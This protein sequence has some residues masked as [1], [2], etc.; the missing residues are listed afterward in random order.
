VLPEG[1]EAR[2]RA[3]LGS[4]YEDFLAS[5]DRPLCTGLRRNPLKTGF[6]GDLSRF[7]L[8]PVPWCPTGFY[9]DAVSRPGLSPYHAAGL[10][11]LQE[12]SAMAPAELLDPQPGERVLDLCAAPGGKST[13][14]AGKLR[15]KGLLVCNEI[16]AKRAKILSGNIERLG[17]S[18]A[19]VLNEHPKRLEERFAGYFDKILVDAPCSGE[20]MFRKNEEA[21]EQWSTQNVELCADRQDEILDC[22]A[23]ML[24]G[25]GR[26]VYSTCTFAPAEDEGSIGRFLKRHPEFYVEEVPLAE[27][28]SH[29]LGE[30]SA[31]IRLWP[32]KLRGEGHYVAVL[33]K[34]G[35][36]AD[37]GSGLLKNGYE[38]GITAGD[39]KSAAAGI[40]E[41]LAFAGETFAGDALEKY[42]G[43]ECRYLKFGEQL[44]RIPEGMPSVKGLKVLRPGLHLGTAKKGR[45]EPSHALALTLHAADVLHTMDLPSDGREIR[46]YLN[47]ETFPAQGEKGWYLITVDGYSTGWGKLAGGIMKNHYPKGLRKRLP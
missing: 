17:I 40:P 45:F 12:P 35:T 41:Y 5:F 31:T 19:L 6:T 23:S 20:G 16:N 47:G 44:Y 34:E 25:G 4:E 22:A 8:S 24:A 33:R 21:C 29:G 11:Y 13:Q 28:M 32:H 43:R 18:N 30:L 1:F 27:G 9:Y 2:M 38:N 15:G 7:S 36:L 3:L 42:A 14:L 10:Y 46:G 39:S 26:L 37:G